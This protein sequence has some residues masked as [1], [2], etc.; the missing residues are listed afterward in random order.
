MESL[1]LRRRP[2]HTILGNVYSGG[3]SKRQALP[4]PGNMGGDITAVVTY[5]SH[6]LGGLLLFYGTL[7]NVLFMR[8][9]LA[10]RLGRPGCCHRRVTVWVT[11]FCLAAVAAGFYNL[12]EEQRLDRRVLSSMA[13]FCGLLGFLPCMPL[14]HVAIPRYC[15]VLH[16]R[17]PLAFLLRGI[18]QGLPQSKRSSFFCWGSSGSGDYCVLCQSQRFCALSIAL[19]AGPL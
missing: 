18:H 17:L 10:I 7:M 8:T 14:W 11:V 6:H 15:I 16:C 1:A 12:W 19:E 2:S 13:L 5:W 9:V 3:G 4:A